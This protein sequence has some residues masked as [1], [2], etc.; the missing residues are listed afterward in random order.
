MPKI[1]LENRHKVI[2][3]N[4]E[5]K[6]QSEISRKLGISRCGIQQILKKHKETG[7]V[8]D[9]PRSGRPSKL[10][11]TDTKYLKLSSL[12][13]R[14]KSSREL[15]QNLAETSGVQ[16]HASTVRRAL[17]KEGLN[18]RVARAKP[19]LRKVNKTKRLKYAR[20]HRNWTSE[21]WKNVLWTDESK[22]EIFSS[23]RR[24]YVR[25]RNGESLKEIC[26]KPTIKHGGGSIN[27]WGCLSANG[28][29]DLVR[30]DGI[31]NAEKYKQILIHHGIPSGKRL[32]GNKFI[33]QQYND[34]KNT[35][36]IV[37]RYLER[38]KTLVRLN[39]WNGHLRVQT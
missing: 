36:N 33:F 16:V 38:K 24:Q 18:G 4:E 28:V 7:K 35:A 23:K 26:L 8:S 17:I 12:R 22:F 3:L 30:I 9:K 13:D 20:S 27:V 14:R 2:F 39:S 5:G 29:G 10:S 1:S 37:K 25:R 15:S 31:M 21:Q 19:L 32:I 6:S 34:P 11:K